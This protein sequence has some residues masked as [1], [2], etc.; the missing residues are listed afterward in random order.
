VK[1]KHTATQ[2]ALATAEDLL[3][4]LLTGLAGSSAQSSGG[5]GYMGQIADARAR[6]AQAAAEEEQARV[7]LDMSK[8]ELG[9]LEKRWKAVEREAGQG[10]RDIK[11]MQAEAESLQKKADATGWST[12]KEQAND[13]ALRRAKDD[14][15]RC[16]HVRTHPLLQA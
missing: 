3:Q 9:E 14:A 8:R 12:E 6:L 7:K 11:K 15:M 13:E 2:T 4:T 10:E 5:G 1:E 16:T